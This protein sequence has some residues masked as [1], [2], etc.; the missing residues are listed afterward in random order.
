M[1]YAERLLALDML[2]LAYDRE[3]K[4]LLL[5]YKAST[6]IYIEIGITNYV[7]LNNHPLG[8]E[9]RGRQEK[10]NTACLF[11]LAPSVTRVVIFVSRAFSL[12]RLRK[13]RDCP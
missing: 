11:C 12:D 9:K 13:K 1:S 8:R 7:T 5:F 3:I 2:L 10:R 6:T 4:H